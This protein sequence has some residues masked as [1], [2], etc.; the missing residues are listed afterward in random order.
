MIPAMSIT[1]SGDVDQA[2]WRKKGEDSWIDSNIRVSTSRADSNVRVAPES[3]SNALVSSSRANSNVR[4]AVDQTKTR[5]G[6]P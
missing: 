2:T 1:D 6:Y 4:V 3:N 5:P